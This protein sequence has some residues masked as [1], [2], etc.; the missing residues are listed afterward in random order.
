MEYKKAFSLIELMISLITISC[1]I[2]A[3][4]PVMT[5][6]LK[7]SSIT[8]SLSEITTKCDKFSS[9]CTLCYSDKC[10]VCSIYCNENQY[11]NDGSCICENCSEK[12]AGCIRC[13][14]KQCRKCA[15]GYGLTIDGKCKQCSAGYYSDGTYDCIA[16]PIDQYQNQKGKSSCIS[17]PAN[18][19]A[20][21][22]SSSCTTCSTKITNC[23]ECSNLSQCTKCDAG[24]YLNSNNTCTQC[25][26]GSYCNGESQ[27]QC[28]AGQYQNLTGQ[29][30]CKNCPAGQYQNLTG[31]SSC[32]NCSSVTLNCNTCN[33]TTGT[34]TTCSNGYM[35]SGTSCIAKYSHTKT[36]NGSIQN[37]NIDNSTA[38]VVITSIIGAG[39]GGGGGYTKN[40]TSAPKTVTESFCKQYGWTYISA[41]PHCAVSKNAG[42][43]NNTTTGPSLNFI[44]SVPN[45]KYITYQNGGNINL[46]ANRGWNCVGGYTGKEN[47]ANGSHSYDGKSRTVCQLA[48]AKAICAAWAPNGISGWE[49]PANYHLAGWQS[50]LKTNTLS[51]CSRYYPCGW[52]NVECAQVHWGINPYY[53]WMNGYNSDY[54]WI[55][56]NCAAGNIENAWRSE[57]ITNPNDGI[58]LN[59]ALSTRCILQKAVTTTET[60]YKGGGGGSGYSAN[61]VTIPASTISSARGG[62]IRLTAGTGGAGGAKGVKGNNGN[63][64]KV[65]VINS[66]GSV[67]WTKSVTTGSGGKA[68]SDS[69]NGAGGTGA[70]SG[71]TGGAGGG[72]GYGAGG[73]GGSGSSSGSNGSAGYISVSYQDA[74]P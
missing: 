42:D 30:S 27:A 65:E 66:S 16:C 73:A 55:Y 59:N 45:V 56:D 9:N 8:A 58:V 23:L 29:S 54:V 52:G 38:N 63:A 61:N 4:A 15:S 47:V 6:K 40:E 34:C 12:Y 64:T 43:G 57:G 10:I 37:I 41:G 5:K 13:D 74:N 51:V 36:A 24:Y 26:K 53:Y 70:I 72:S 48:A 68:A 50:V 25:P 28:P 71:T 2:A 44:I 46:G 11:K 1:I 22:G 3:F 69:G 60:P 19:G 62:I 35:L 67:I 7:N 32:K 18:Q 14:D 33:A 49:L 17:C 31:Q 39:G 20:E 21:V